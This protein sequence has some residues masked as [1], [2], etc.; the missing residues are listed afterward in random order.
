MNI[1][2]VLAVYNKL[3]LTQAIADGL[4]VEEYIQKFKGNT[5]Y[6]PKFLYVHN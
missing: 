1:T 3:D 4:F 5:L 6:I 2:F